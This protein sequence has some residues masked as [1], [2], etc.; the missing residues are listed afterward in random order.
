M[1]RN[2]SLRIAAVILF[3]LAFLSSPRAQAAPSASIK[4]VPSTIAIGAQYNGIAIDLNGT[5][6]AGSEVILRFSGEPGELH[7]REK[8]K[9]FGLLW[10]N[11]GKVSL[12]NVPSVCLI[13]SSAAFDIIG[14]AAIP[15]RLEGLRDI[16]TVG[17]NTGASD[18]DVLEELLLLK[19]NQ[20]L[21]VEESRGVRL[22][23]D[24]GSVRPF[25]ASMKVPSA[26]APGKYLVEAIAIKDGAVVGRSTTTVD[27][28]LTGFP[29]WLS[30]LAFKRSL[31]YGA[32]ATLIAIFSGLLI[33]I[34]FQG[35]GGAH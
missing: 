28:A 30:Q 34:I 3:L 13:D 32:L 12:S 2:R 23:P 8:G 29:R 1:T 18:I 22:G 20:K 16:I 19:K 14:A 26:L 15:Y 9:I 24:T 10:M 6:P 33:G 25:S 17:E 35:K 7:L 31:L 27:A 5:I 11:V 21:Y 4:A